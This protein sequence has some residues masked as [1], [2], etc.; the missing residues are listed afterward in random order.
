MMAKTQRA[1]TTA[2]IAGMSNE[3]KAFPK[4]LKNPK[5]LKVASKAPY[6]GAA[7][8]TYG[9]A[10]SVNNIIKN[11]MNMTPYPGSKNYQKKK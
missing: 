4:F 3:T 9:I 10:K 1:I 5:I 2:K 11:K 7:L 6:V 8:A